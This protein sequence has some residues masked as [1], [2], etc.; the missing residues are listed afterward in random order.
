MYVEVL[1]QWQEVGERP[2]MLCEQSDNHNH[3]GFSDTQLADLLQKEHSKM[4]E[5]GKSSDPDELR[6]KDDILSSH[7]LQLSWMKEKLEA[8]VNFVRCRGAYAT[9]G[10][11]PEAS[12]A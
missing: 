6:V 1:R 2:S 10:V 12:D 4:V 9:I 11:G 5:D 3:F 8:E 7:V